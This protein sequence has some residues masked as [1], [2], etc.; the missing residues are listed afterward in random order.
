MR[1]TFSRISRLH[2]VSRFELGV[3]FVGEGLI[4]FDLGIDVHRV[5]LIE[6]FCS[7]E[8]R[9]NKESLNS[10]RADLKLKCFN[11]SYSRLIYFT[12]ESNHGV[13]FTS[14]SMLGGAVRS[15]CW[16]SSPSGG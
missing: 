12:Y 16:Y 1:N 11:S 4:V 13:T 3:Q 5:V 9:L 6:E 10:E 8:S 14:N 15:Q 7:K 2:L